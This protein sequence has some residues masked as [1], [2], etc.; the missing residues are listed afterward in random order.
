MTAVALAT[1]ALLGGVGAVGAGQAD[2]AAQA[3]WSPTHC[4]T[5]VGRVACVDLTHQRFWIQDGSK[6]IYG[7]VRVRT[8]RAG[9]VTRD[10]LFHIYSRQR[11]HWSTLYNVEMPY[12]QF[13]SGGEALHAVFIPISTPPGS[14]GCVNM[15]MHDAAAA[16]NLL[17]LGSPVDV[18]GRKP[19]T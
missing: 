12:S 11:N 5:N 3:R 17:K 7:P 16:W 9:Y 6:I 14:H 13:F 8:G 15:T 4:L 18:F 19:G 1:A 2:A 10:G